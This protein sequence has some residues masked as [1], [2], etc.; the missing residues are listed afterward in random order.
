MDP[1]YF[2]I[3]CNGLVV[4]KGKVMAT[5]LDM[6]LDITLCENL[7]SYLIHDK[8]DSPIKKVTAEVLDC[9][10]WPGK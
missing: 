7:P 3:Y 2:P 9:I 8:H 1:I 6:V 5:Q 10:R 4:R